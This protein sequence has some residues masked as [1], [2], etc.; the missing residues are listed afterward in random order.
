MVH[1]NGIF[2]FLFKRAFQRYAARLG[3]PIGP[4]LHPL[5][6]SLTNSPNKTSK[7]CVAV[8]A[9]SKIAAWECGSCTYTNE[10]GE[11]GPCIMCRTERPIHYA[12]VAGA[13]VAA[14]AR[15]TTVNRREQARVAASAT[16]APAADAGEA[17]AIARPLMPVAV[18]NCGT[19][20]R[21]TVIAQLVSTLIDIVGT[22]ASNRG[23]SCVSKT[24]IGAGIVPTII[25]DNL[26]TN[27]I[28]L[29]CFMSWIVAY[30]AYTTVRVTEK[31][32]TDFRGESS[33]VF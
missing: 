8:M 9:P 20:S 11:P 29:V 31:C 32:K 27:T 5:R 22:G 6:S 17:A 7:R 1:L 13:P 2:V 19:Q 23:R 24:Y 28:H 21:D 10:G 16:T 18:L 3:S 30:A 15:T 4:K 12:I 25:H 14:T 33:K 26:A